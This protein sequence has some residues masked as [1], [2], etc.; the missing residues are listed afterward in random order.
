MRIAGIANTSGNKID[1]HIV[2]KEVITVARP[3]A[4]PEETPT[5]AHNTTSVMRSSSFIFI[6]GSKMLDAK[7][8]ARLIKYAVDKSKMNSPRGYS[9]HMQKGSS[10]SDITL[11]RE[12]TN[13]SVAC[14]YLT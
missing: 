5:I 7:A 3:D 11:P 8:T 2:I 10:G 9:E 13:A 12:T 6:C 4:S 1:T 14:T